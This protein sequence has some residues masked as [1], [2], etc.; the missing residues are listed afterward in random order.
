MRECHS[1]RQQKKFLNA[2]SAPQL[3]F[4]MPINACQSHAPPLRKRKRCRRMLQRISNIMKQAKRVNNKLLNIT[5]EL[6]TCWATGRLI[7]YASR[8]Q[9][10]SHKLVQPANI[11]INFRQP[12][13]KYMHQFLN[14]SEIFLVLSEIFG[15]RFGQLGL[16]KVMY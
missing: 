6:G 10:S 7:L 4:G 1:S 8:H 3:F 9:S 2:W 16:V 12:S 14:I 11:C 15:T 5:K 13:P